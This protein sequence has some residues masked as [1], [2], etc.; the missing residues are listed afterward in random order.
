[1]IFI[2]SNS[3]HLIEI[4]ARIWSNRIGRIIC[5]WT[6]SRIVRT[7]WNSK[8]IE[9]TGLW[10]YQKN[11]FE[12]LSLCHILNFYQQCLKSFS[13]NSSVA[14]NC[15]IHIQKILDSV[16]NWVYITIRIQN[17]YGK[18]LDNFLAAICHIQWMLI[19]FV[20]EKRSQGTSQENEGWFC[21]GNFWMHPFQVRIQ[22]S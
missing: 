21:L 1:V 13:E 11:I 20:I 3:L 10:T 15:L 22:F 9:P 16:S 4:T 8:S 6:G 7:Q 14:F 2:V 5:Q 18:L 12:E 19:C 17:I